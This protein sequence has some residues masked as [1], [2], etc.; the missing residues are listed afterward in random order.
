MVLPWC[1]KNTQID[2]GLSGRPNKGLCVHCALVFF[3][4]VVVSGFCATEL[5]CFKDQVKYNLYASRLN[6]LW[7]GH[8]D[9]CIL[10]VIYQQ[11]STYFLSSFAFLLV[12]TLIGGFPHP[13][14]QMND[15]L[16]PMLGSN[17]D[18]D[19]TT[20]CRML[21]T[22]QQ[23]FSVFGSSFQCTLGCHPVG[24]DFPSTHGWETHQQVPPVL[25]KYEYDQ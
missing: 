3:I 10:V 6:A 23:A 1:I 4:I 22:A 9:H 15:W 20:S 12:A 7:H 18:W 14:L 11:K 24:L 25:D 21:S 5:W 19:Y 17:W 8:A 16:N 13:H 2:L